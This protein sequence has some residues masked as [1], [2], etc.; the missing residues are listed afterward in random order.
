[1]QLARGQFGFGKGEPP[2][3]RP[4]V[5]PLVEFLPIGL[6]VAHYCRREETWRFGGRDARVQLDGIQRVRAGVPNR[7]F[8]P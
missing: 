3:A 4:Q 8:E 5:Q 2:T 7:V 6:T 1:M